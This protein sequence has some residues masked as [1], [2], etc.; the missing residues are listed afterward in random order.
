MKYKEIKDQIQ[1]IEK[2]L[3]SLKPTKQEN[4]VIRAG[5]QAQRLIYMLQEMDGAFNQDRS[6]IIY[7]LESLS[8]AGWE[9]SEAYKTKVETL[10]DGRSVT[11][12]LERQVN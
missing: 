6:S 7:Q 4:T 1:R 11:Q 2:C 10:M 9:T 12:W 3:A 8:Y 5:V